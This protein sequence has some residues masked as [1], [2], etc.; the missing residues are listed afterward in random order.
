MYQ[1]TLSNAKKTDLKTTQKA[2]ADI[3]SYF[4]ARLSASLE[5]TQ[6]TAPLFVK[7]SSGLNDNLSGVEKPVAFQPKDLAHNLEIVQSL[8]KWKRQ[9]LAQYGFTVGEGLYTNMNA[10]RQDESLDSTHSVYVDQWDW[11]LAIS[12]TQ[13]NQLFLKQIVN[14]IYQAIR[15]TQIYSKQKYKITSSILPTNIKFISSQELENKYPKLTAK[16]REQA[17]CYEHKAVFLM[18]IGHKLKSGISHDYRA[19]DYDDW[20]LNGDILVW[21]ESLNSSLELSSMGIRVDKKSLVKQCHLSNCLNRLKLKYHQLIL[22]ELL[23]LTIGGGI[24]QSRL[25][26]FMLNKKHIGEVQSSIW[27][28]QVIKRCRELGINLLM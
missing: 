18:Q 11:E 9:A 3:K 16:E 20:T 15:K 8:A 7:Q 2:I 10:I 5:L 25:C 23:P 12:E 19:P 22:N 4:Q 28:V 1:A 26:L 13:R 21:S 17:I 27:S 6:V 24:G 14:K